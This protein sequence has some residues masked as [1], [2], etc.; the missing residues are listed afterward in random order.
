MRRPFCVFAARHTM[1][2]LEIPQPM[3]LVK[4]EYDWPSPF[5]VGRFKPE[6]PVTKREGDYD[7]FGFVQ[8]QGVGKDV[9]VHI[10]TVEWAGL[11]TLNEGAV[12]EY[13]VIA[14]KGKESA[15]DIKVK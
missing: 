14:N 1:R 4:N 5:G 10:S 6:H 7:G 13:E 9:F 11:S 12:I 2:R 3:L 8:R 15:E